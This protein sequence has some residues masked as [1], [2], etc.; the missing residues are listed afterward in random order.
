VTGAQKGNRVTVSQKLFDRSI[1][2]LLSR[3][4]PRGLFLVPEIK[5][6]TKRSPI[7]DGR[8]ERRKFDTGPSRHPEKQ[9]PGRIPELE[10]KNTGSGVSR[11]EGSTLKE[12]NLIKLYVKQLIKNKKCS[13][14]FWTAL[15][16]F[17]Y[18]HFTGIC[19]HRSYYSPM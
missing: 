7:S 3:F 19:Y 8:G 10:T 1:A 9:V 6:L 17:H 5:I 2:A 14:S 16:F 13:V 4:G 12:T 18:P 15:I 11:A